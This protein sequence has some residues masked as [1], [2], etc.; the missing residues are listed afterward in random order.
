MSTT[1]D[2]PPEAN[3]IVCAAEPASSVPA[4]VRAVNR[5]LDAGW[6][7]QLDGDSTTVTLT[8]QRGGARESGVIVWKLNDE[9]EWRFLSCVID[10]KRYG[11]RQIAE[12]LAQ[13]APP[14]P[15]C[16]NGCA[17]WCGGQVCQLTPAEPGANPGAL[18][19]GE[20]DVP[21]TIVAVDP[22]VPMGLATVHPIRPP[23]AL[24]TVHTLPVPARVGMEPLAASAL[25]ASLAPPVAPA[26]GV[27]PT[28]TLA[29]F[30][31]AAPRATPVNGNSPWATA[32]AAELREI[33]EWHG[34]HSPRN[35]QV[36]LGPSELGVPCDRQ[37]AGKMAGI[38]TTNHVVDPWP[39]IVGTAGHA[40]LDKAFKAE[41][42]RHGLRWVPENRVTPH[43]DHPGTADL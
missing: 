13:P 19:P 34:N 31:S 25:T 27:M 22:G 12:R 5:A 38:P 20:G 17:T 8:V 28:G 29:S 11:A 4:A 42:A 14:A 16:P 21:R 41:N 6:T 35:L 15:Q 24:A 26:G 40:W 2:A 30:M 37:V 18:P 10:G 23:D 36:A 1:T 33:I 3:K 7:T 43:P 32:Y 39:S 9:G